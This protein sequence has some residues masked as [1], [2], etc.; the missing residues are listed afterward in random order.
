[1]AIITG[2]ATTVTAE[3]IAEARRTPPLGGEIRL[4]AVTTVLSD[5][6]F[7]DWSTQMAAIPP[8]TQP[9]PQAPEVPE[10]PHALTKGMQHGEDLAR[11]LMEATGATQDELTV[12]IRI[13]RMQ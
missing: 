5:P 11:K 8:L 13:S 3:M 4:F 7:E 6:L 9:D 2:M 12:A 1:M 10:D